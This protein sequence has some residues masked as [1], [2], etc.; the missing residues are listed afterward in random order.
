MK[1]MNGYIIYTDPDI[2]GPGELFPLGWL[3]GRPHQSVSFIAVRNVT[4]HAKS[5]EDFDVFVAKDP[6]L[7]EEVIS[8]QLN[9]HDR[10]YNLNLDNT[11]ER[12][13]HCILTLA[14]RFGVQSGQHVIIEIPL[15][16]QEF[17]DLVR[18]SRETTGKILNKFES[19]GYIILGRNRILADVNKLSKILET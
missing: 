6:F 7:L 17:A 16:Q 3:F 11:E 12:V 18:L 2:Y 5:R 19:E 10:I 4:L 9:M 14:H 1:A 13:A 8:M 15:T